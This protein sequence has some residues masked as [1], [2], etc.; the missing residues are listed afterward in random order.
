MEFRMGI[1]L[2][3]VR[4]EGER[5]FGTGVNIA[6]RLEGLAEPGGLCISGAV[7]EQLRGKLDLELEDLGEQSVK[8]IPEP[9][10]VFRV[11]LEGEAAEAPPRPSRRG[12]LGAGLVVL[13]AAALAAAW[14]MRAD[15]TTTATVSAPI[16]SIAVLPLENLSGPEHDYVVAGLHDALIASLARAGP[17]LRVTSRTT[18]S[19]IDREG[20]TIPELAA[21]LLVDGVIEGSA[22]LEGDRVLVTVQLIDARADSHLWADS[23]ERPFGGMIALSREISRTVADEVRLVLSPERER[24]LAEAHRVVP[25]A[26]EAYTQGIRELSADRVDQAIARFEEATRIDPE[27]AQAFGMLSRGYVR[28]NYK[29]G[30]PMNEWIP[31]A[32]TA[33]QRALELDDTIASAHVSLG[34]IA[35]LRDFDWDEAGREFQHAV[36]LDPSDP[37]SLDAWAF[38]NAARGRRA[39]SI[40]AAERLLGVAPLDPM[41]RSFAAFYFYCARMYERAIE[42]ALAILAEH[43]GSMQVYFYLAPAYYQTGQLAEAQSAWVRGLRLAGLEYLAKALEKGYED[44]GFE[45]MLRGHLEAEKERATPTSYYSVATTC[46]GL[47]DLDCAFEALEASYRNERERAR[48]LVTGVDPMLD[49]LRSDPRFQDLLRR[50]EYPGAS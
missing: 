48:I 44:A 37:V 45:G 18:V 33:A 35:W 32:Q 10:H 17:E 26:L 3:D 20:R 23:Y 21:E 30:L 22:M 13:L 49:P 14:W 2:G 9:V 34:T 16:R 40:T 7:R 47:G 46:A 4:F 8:N 19:E 41:N 24:L 5:I 39:E 1:H 28:L 42:E 27:Y 50:I 12:M 38:Y 6:A 36:D 15:P 29:F 31:G 11:R 43:P 25:A